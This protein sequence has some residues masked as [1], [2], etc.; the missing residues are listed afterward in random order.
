MR[1]EQNPTHSQSRLLTRVLSAL[2]YDLG[3]F[4]RAEIA[5][6]DAETLAIVISLMD[7]HAGGALTREDWTR[8]ADAAMAAQR[9]AES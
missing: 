7:A 9:G 4:R 8:A 5:A 2:T 6:F 3:E 1:I